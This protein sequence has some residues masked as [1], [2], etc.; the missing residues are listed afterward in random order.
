M[1]SVLFPYSTEVDLVNEIKATLKNIQVA[2]QLSNK[3]FRLEVTG[4]SIFRIVL[5]NFLAERELLN[6]T[7]KAMKKNFAKLSSL[8]REIKLQIYFGFLSPEDFNHLIK[9]IKL[10]LN[11]ISGSLDFDY[12]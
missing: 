10:I 2:L 3:A 5:Y 7:E 8:N 9:S 12:V 6:T 4:C 1:N 11:S